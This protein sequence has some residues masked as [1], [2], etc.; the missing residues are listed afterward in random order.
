MT[1][2]HD[3]SSMRF[4]VARSCAVTPI[5]DHALNMKFYWP[6]R[7]PVQSNIRWVVIKQMEE[8]FE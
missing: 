2:N 3:G 5:H 1:L 4:E 8:V 6:L 7:R